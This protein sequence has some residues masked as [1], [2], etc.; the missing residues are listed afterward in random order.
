MI[1]NPKARIFYVEDD[2]ALS[3]VTQDNLEREGYE[4]ISCADGQVAME[5]IHKPE[6]FDL[7]ILDV[8]L[9]KVDG[10][11]LAIEI[12]KDDA[13]VRRNLIFLDDEAARSTTTWFR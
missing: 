12:R 7:V 10:Y 2:E 8:M 9:P 13:G 11:N 1:E 6:L 4:V 3:F 5:M